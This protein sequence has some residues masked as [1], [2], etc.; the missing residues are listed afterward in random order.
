MKLYVARHGQTQWN[1]E[2]RILGRTDLPLNELGRQQALAL[3][4]KAENLDLDLIISSPLLRARETAQA[5][6]DRLGIPV[7]VESRL[8]EQDFG[9]YEGQHHKVADYLENKKQFAYRYP[10][11]ESALG[12]AH[13]VYGFLEE[14]R[15]RCPDRKVLLVC[16]RCICRIIRTYF[17]DMTNEEFLLYAEENG[18]VRAY[19][20]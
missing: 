19:D 3:A 1:L 2:N 4:E 10:G 16:H 8:T 12:V 5:V 14:L 13:R 18:A 11:G 9:I 6:S 20:L 17:E 7:I 15:D